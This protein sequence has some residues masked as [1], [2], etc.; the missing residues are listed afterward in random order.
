MNF[1]LALLGRWGSDAGEDDARSEY[2]VSIEN[3]RLTV[4]GRDCVDHEPF[5]ISNITYDRN[6]VEFDTLMPSTGRAGHLI[7]V[8]IGVP[9][10][11]QMKF[12]FTDTAIVKKLIDKA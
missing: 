2:H 7:L 3:G 4:M 8:D 5:I 12:T 9:D 1:P 6:R 11:A 10:A